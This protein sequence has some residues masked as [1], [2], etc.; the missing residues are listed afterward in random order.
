MYA[1][2]QD[3]HVVSRKEK[4]AGTTAGCSFRDLIQY[5]A[6]RSEVVEIIGKYV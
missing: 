4:H 5:A 3:S 2:A 1:I 6:A